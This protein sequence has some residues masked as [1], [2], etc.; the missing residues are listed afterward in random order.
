VPAFEEVESQVETGW[1]EE[2]RA[3]IREKAFAAMRERYQV[4][5]PK[6]LPVIEPP[7]LAVVVPQ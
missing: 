3:E 2:Q 5:V 4:V 7:P 6:E 1:I